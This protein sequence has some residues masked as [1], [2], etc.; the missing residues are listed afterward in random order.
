MGTMSPDAYARSLAYALTCH[1]RERAMRTVPYTI[2]YGSILTGTEF[3]EALGE[4]A[5]DLKTKRALKSA[6]KKLHPSQDVPRSKPRIL[7]RD[8]FA[9][10]QILIFCFVFVFV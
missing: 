8:V 7:G 4:K 10:K 3:R 5:Q 6:N 9:F 2:P 1:K